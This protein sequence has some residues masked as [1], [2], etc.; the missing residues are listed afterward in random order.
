MRRCAVDPC[1]APVCFVPNLVKQVT[2][3]NS[4]SWHFS[5]NCTIEAAARMLFLLTFVCSVFKY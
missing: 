1:A 5:S 2:G 3:E 4:G